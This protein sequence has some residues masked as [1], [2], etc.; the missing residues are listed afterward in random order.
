MTEN[1][2]PT[3]NYIDNM[4]KI[5]AKIIYHNHLITSSEVEKN[6]IRDILISFLNWQN[7]EI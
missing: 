3:L 1:I 7:I 2:R 4:F 6:K 5:V